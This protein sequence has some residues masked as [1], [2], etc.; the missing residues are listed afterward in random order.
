[1]LVGMNPPRHVMKSTPLEVLT[2]PEVVEMN[3][4][5]NS[6]HQNTFDIKKLSNVVV[7]VVNVLYILVKS[8][9]S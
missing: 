1:M 6:L 4:I 8:A 5:S 3:S 2:I 7:T 9:L